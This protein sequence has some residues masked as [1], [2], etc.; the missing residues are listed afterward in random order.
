MKNVNSL[1]EQK[2]IRAASHGKW[3][4]VL[5]RLEFGR[6]FHRSKVRKLL[7]AYRLKAIWLFVIGC[8]LVSGFCKLEAFTGLDFFF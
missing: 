7:I 4:G 2:W 5:H 3:L 6:D 8:P 1:F